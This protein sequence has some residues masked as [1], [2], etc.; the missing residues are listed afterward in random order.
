[1][2]K[3][4][5][6]LIV[7]FFTIAA[8]EV[9]AQSAPPI[10]GSSG[11]T[12]VQKS[13]DT[14]NDPNDG[15]LT[16]G[17][18]TIQPPR[19]PQA[20]QPRR[21]VRK[22]APSSS[23]SVSPSSLRPIDPAR[24]AIVE[25]QM[26]GNYPVVSRLPGLPL[27]TIQESWDRPVPSPGQRSPGVVWFEWNPN[28]VMA[29]RTRDYMISTIHFPSWEN[30]K[31]FYIGDPHIFEAQK[32]QTNLLALRSTNPGADT[33]MTVIGTSGNVYN[34]YVR[35]EGWN[36][37]Q[38]TDLTIYINVRKGGSQKAGMLGHP[39]EYGP[40]LAYSG[41]A[42]FGSPTPYAI[43]NTIPAIPNG[44]GYVPSG[45]STPAHA[46]ALNDGLALYPPD[47]IR[48]I[49]Y[50]PENLQFDM[51]MY[52]ETIDDAEIAPERVFHDGVFTYLDYGQ[53]AENIRRP[54]VHLVID[55]SDTLINTRTAGPKNNVIIVEAVGDLTLRN[56]QKIV[57]IRQ[58]AAP[59]VGGAIISKESGIERQSK[60]PGNGEGIDIGTTTL[61]PGSE[62]RK[63]QRLAP[64]SQGRSG[65][66]GVEVDQLPIEKDTPRFSPRP[67][68]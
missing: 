23:S 25:D 22:P 56:G 35:S 9:Q 68:F 1:M 7:T 10:P 16:R 32:V 17:L 5:V 49:A 39:K 46:Q 52:A 34:F 24:R 26:R 61:K 59:R 63:I 50:R 41:G 55:G 21:T 43:G 40:D 2:K 3:F 29:I 64:K 58:H 8:A 66:S 30:I 44:S 4:L 51:K 62:P 33:N 65:R 60:M 6:L 14:S 45:L 13:R 20:P 28:H 53:N 37:N 19:P 15:R 42:P 18:S 36:T 38:I 48:Q 57:C 12:Y 47:Y 54:V 31:T 11:A 67:I 27:G